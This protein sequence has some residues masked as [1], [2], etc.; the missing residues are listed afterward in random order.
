MSVHHVCG[1][2]EW[3]EGEC[4]H[5]PLVLTEEG[6]TFIEMDSKTHK[7]VCDTVVDRAWLKTL[8]FYNTIRNNTLLT[9]PKGAF[10]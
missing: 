4:S 9:L 10:Q 3:V 1:E 6:K 7:A 2:H 8:V 5:G